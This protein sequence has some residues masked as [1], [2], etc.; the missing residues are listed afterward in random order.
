MQ[1]LVAGVV[2]PL[3]FWQG[4]AMF[5]FTASVDGQRLAQSGAQGGGQTGQVVVTSAGQIQGQVVGGLPKYTRHSSVANIHHEGASSGSSQD[6]HL[7]VGPQEVH[8]HHVVSSIVDESSN[9]PTSP[10]SAASA[11][12]SA[13]PSPSSPGSFPHFF[14]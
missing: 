11:E 5:S 9:P 13:P 1:G 14:P 7:V 12:Q 3:S 10:S 2:W 4:P 6:G 8:G